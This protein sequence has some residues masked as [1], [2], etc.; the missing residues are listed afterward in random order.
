MTLNP[1]KT[2][3]VLLNL[4]GPDSLRSVKPF[5]FNLFY[6]PAIIRLSR[7]LRWIVAQVISTLRDKKA[8][9]IYSLIGGKSSLLEETL[10]QQQAL[11]IVLSSRIN[12][13]FKSFICM[14]HWHPRASE[15]LENIKNFSPTE[16]ILVPL[17]PQFSSTTSGSSINEFKSLVAGDAGLSNVP[18]K[19]LCCYFNDE[20][21][22]D[23]HISLIKDAIGKLHS[24][25]N[26]RILFSAHSLP[27]KIIDEGD[28]YQWQ[29]EQT[30][31]K[32]VS[33]LHM[34]GLD[35]KITYQSRATPVEWLKPDTEEEIKAACTIKK[36]LIIVPIA[37]VSEHVET[38]VELDIEYK[39]LADKDKIQYTRVPTLGINNIFIEALSEMIVNFSN[40]N[41]HLSNCKQ[42][43]VCPQNFSS[44]PY[45]N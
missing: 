37:F 6:D 44:C 7:P 9:N 32:I 43:R 19:T 10:K 34:P 12:T 8:Q 35:Y 2:A 11:D 26:Y 3:I 41:Q 45:K 33:K 21:F 14:R 5:L 4:G 17:Y 40:N 23:A 42:M 1:K 27:K 36:S 18:L 29:I 16:I 13:K 15:V 28:P 22:I 38:L 39:A 31:A 24:N 20:K 30:V 25:E